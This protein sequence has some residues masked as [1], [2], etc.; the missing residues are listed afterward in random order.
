MNEPLPAAPP[1]EEDT[2]E[3]YRQLVAA[4]ENESPIVF[5]TGKAGS[6]KS[7]LV[8]RLLESKRWP[9]AVVAPTGIAAL[10]V[11][12]ATIH[13]FFK[14]PPRLLERRDVRAVRDPSV[15]QNLRLL[16]IDEVSMVRADLMDAIA[17][18]LDLNGPDPSKPFGGVQLVLVGDL[19]QLQPVVDQD[20]LHVFFR[21]VYRSP[22]FFNSRALRETPVAAIELERI[23]R[24]RDPRFAQLLNSIREGRDIASAID[25]IN[26]RC[27]REP[28]ESQVDEPRIILTPTNRAAEARNGSALRAIEHPGRIYTAV[29]SGLFDPRSERLPS[30]AKLELKPG[31]QVMFTKNDP[32][33]R[34]VNGMLGVVRELDEDRVHVELASNLSK[35]VVEVKPVSWQTLHYKWDEASGEIKREVTGEFLQLPLMLG[36]AT[37]IHKSQGKTLDAV[38]IDLERGAFAPGQVYVALSRCRELGGITLTRPIRE[39]DVLCD[40]EIIE[41]YGELRRRM[42][43]EAEPG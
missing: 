16:V 41:F 43:P 15:F 8:R 24:Q 4:I 35:A 1:F 19:F 7:T 5:L 26:E 12:G 38:E 23:F 3:E 20:D 18:F 9:T 13:S 42:P 2:S 10:N 6:G 31:A 29:V 21:K 22:H 11:G 40:P 37:T 32:E 27:Y 14:F 30:P 36:W 34:W 28:G 25:F 39:A 17:W 33:K